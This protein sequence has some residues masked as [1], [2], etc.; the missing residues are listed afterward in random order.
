MDLHRLRCFIKIVEEGSVSKAAEAMNM[1]Q[2]PLSI[3]MGKLEKELKVSLFDRS[4][5]RLTL[6][7][8]GEFLYQRGKELIASTENMVK[9][10]SE[11]NDG[12]RGTVTA[13]CITSA[14]LFI[15]PDAVKK[16]REEAPN[17]IMRVKEGNSSFVLN[18]L[19]NHKIDIGIVRTI[20]EAEDL[21]IS[22]LLTEPL[23]LA[24]PP[25]HPL[26]EKNSISIADLRDEKF[27]LPTSSH[28]SG[29]AEEIMEA[30][31]N[32]GFTPNVIYW[33][34][35]VFPMLLMVMKG[36]G[37]SFAPYNFSRIHWPELPKLVPLAEPKLE[38]K[39]SLVTLQKHYQPSTVQ[40]FLDITR[41]VA[42]DLQP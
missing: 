19:R 18:E 27:I 22:T 30:C 37:I 35:E 29:I 25:G 21:H 4:G 8:D 26:L 32:S 24:L 28:G 6:T 38:T 20:F 15:I 13:G 36:V 5:R 31:N 34:T 3:M 17:I 14:N 2:P 1:T 40:R 23:L 39:L 10:L 16:L 33:G 11:H 7:R 41:A 42:R 12:M 9:E